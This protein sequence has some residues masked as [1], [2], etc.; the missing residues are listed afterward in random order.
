MEKFDCSNEIF[1]VNILRFSSNRDDLMRPCKPFSLNGLDPYDYILWLHP[2]VK[3]FDFI[4][5]LSKLYKRKMKLIWK[6]LNEKKIILD[7]FFSG[8]KYE[9]KRNTHKEYEIQ[10]SLSCLLFNNN[11]ILIKWWSVTNKKISIDK[12]FIGKCYKNS[13]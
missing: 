4:E 5:H 6:R 10:N 12:W 2:V 11:W 8:F 9:M 3:L 1:Y 7:V 13:S